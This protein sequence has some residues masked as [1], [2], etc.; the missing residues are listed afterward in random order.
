M[1][2]DATAETFDDLVATG[3]VV[4]DF[5]GPR[6]QP[7]LALTPRLEELEEDYEGRVRVV[8]VDASQQRDICRR[9]GVLGLPTFVFLAE[10]VEV[11][12]L[13]G[14]EV[15]VA[16]LRRAVAALADGEVPVGAGEGSAGGAPR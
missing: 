5:W 4:A 8:K 10:G 11:G 2:R 16:D 6:C 15:S 7:C 1:A 13:S 9:Y 3:A 12:R 14:G